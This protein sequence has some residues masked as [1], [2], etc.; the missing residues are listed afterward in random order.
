VN[1]NHLYIL[2]FMAILV[3]G[4]Y[5]YNRKSVLARAHD[6]GN[7]LSTGRA[8]SQ[9]W[10]S[11]A[12]YHGYFTAWVTAL[13]TLALFIA[14]LFMGVTALPA[15][16]AWLGVIILAGL[17]TIF[18][19]NRKATPQ[20]RARSYVEHFIKITLI[21][22][23]VIAVLTTFGI[24]MSLLFESLRFFDKVQNMPANQRAKSSSP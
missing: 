18:V 22:L 14:G 21:L 11:Q 19:I 5:L 13:V 3:V 1:P 4:G 23:S 24:I 8:A 6:I 2:V 20:F 9:R 12:N 10:H 16:L 7:A 15:V 17:A